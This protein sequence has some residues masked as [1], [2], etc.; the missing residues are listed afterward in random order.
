M[1]YSEFLADAALAQ[2]RVVDNAQEWSDRALRLRR[3]YLE[4]G[5]VGIVAILRERLA[6]LVGERDARH[7][8]SSETSAPMDETANG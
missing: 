2:Q 1:N 6:Q 7:R 8:Q 4:S 5:R 3:V